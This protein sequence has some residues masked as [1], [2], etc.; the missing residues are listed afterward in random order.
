MASCYG[1]DIG[2]SK[3]DGRLLSPE[4]CPYLPI[5][6]C[7]SLPSAATAEIQLSNFQSDSE[8]LQGF[9]LMNSVITEGRSWPFMDPFPDMLSYRKY[10]HSHDSFAVTFTDKETDG[11]EILGCF[12]VKP[13]FPGR[14][15]HICNG[16]FITNPKFRGLGIG[17]FMGRHFK[18]L[19]KDLGYKA[20][21]FNLV[22]ANNDASI[23]LWRSLGYQ[24]IARIPKAANLEGSAELVDA[25]QVY[26]DF[27]DGK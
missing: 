7:V 20:S 4:R 8:M 2:G 23:N 19:A 26:C 22:F 3:L 5:R 17:K 27:D 15:G 10:F 25:I 21:L 24:E 14:C 11:F 18:I 16:G 9:D 13:N 12:Y 6:D 1:D